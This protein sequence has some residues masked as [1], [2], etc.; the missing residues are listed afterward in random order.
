MSVPKGEDALD[1]FLRLPPS[2]WDE[3]QALW[4]YAYHDGMDWISRYFADLADTVYAI[5]R[6]GALAAM[7]VCVRMPVYTEGGAKTV[8]AAM[9]SGVTVAPQWRGQGLMNR[10]M[11]RVLDALRADGVALAMLYPFKH[12]F[13]ERYG[14]RALGEAVRWT[15]PLDAVRAKA[16]DGCAVSVYGPE[17][18]EK[19]PGAFWERLLGV[20]TSFAKGFNGAAARDLRAMAWRVMEHVR[21]GAW[22]AVAEGAGEPVGYCV[23]RCNGDKAIDVR[24]IVSLSPNAD[25]ALL[26]FLGGHASSQTVAEMVLPL[27][28]TLR[29]AAPDRMGQCVVEPWCMYC[30]LDEELSWHKDPVFTFEK[31]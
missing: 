29:F 7:A 10:L 31:Y 13:Y 6:G 15:L 14:F 19:V 8:S 17:A 9:L 26:A 20:Y 18:L 24:E 27:Q 12:S 5:D 3:A 22:L 2:R 28:S 21:D 4:D 16:P 11:P 1:T 30:P 23:Y 25:L